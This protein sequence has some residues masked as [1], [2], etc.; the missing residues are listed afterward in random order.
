MFVYTAP[1]SK[2]SIAIT[3]TNPNPDLRYQIHGEHV[4]LSGEDLWAVADFFAEVAAQVAPRV[5]AAPTAKG[6]K[7]TKTD[8]TDA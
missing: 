7:K 3:A 4:Q 2:T 5:D 1:V 8:G 6:K